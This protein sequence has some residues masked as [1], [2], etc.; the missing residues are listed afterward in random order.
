MSKSLYTKF[1]K[2]DGYTFMELLVVLVIIGLLAALVGP[3]IFKNLGPAKQTVARTQINNFISAL[4]SYYLDTSN[5]P[6]THQGLNALFE[7]PGDPD[8]KGPYLL[9]SIPNDP[10]GNPFVYRAPGRNGAYEIISF[11]ADGIEGGTDQ[12]KDIVSWEN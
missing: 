4:D 1:K 6:S 11:G 9:K 8:W 10:W 2:E 12:D 7:T 3:A 5:Y